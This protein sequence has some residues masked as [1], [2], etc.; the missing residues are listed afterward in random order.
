M[1]HRRGAATLISG[2]SVAGS[3]GGLG[4][5]GRRSKSCYADDVELFKLTEDTLRL[6]YHESF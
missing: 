2:Y 1:P 3:A 6:N 5:S 4:P